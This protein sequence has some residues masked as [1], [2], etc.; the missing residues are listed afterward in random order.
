MSLVDLGLLFGGAISLFVTIWGITTYVQS[1]K[2]KL[3]NTVSVEEHREVKSNLEK[4]I[5]NLNHELK[6][7]INNFSS[8]HS[9]VKEQL[10]QK[11]S[12]MSVNEMKQDI[13]WIKQHME[14]LDLQKESNLKKND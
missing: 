8:N 2:N 13:K 4:Q 9:S 10:N 6:I 14:Q 11:A 1:I 12:L 5:Q 3:H 7:H